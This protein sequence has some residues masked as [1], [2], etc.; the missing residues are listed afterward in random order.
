MVYSCLGG[1]RHC[2]RVHG[3]CRNAA[4]QSKSHPALVN[5][6]E[7][8]RGIKAT[9]SCVSFPSLV[10][11]T[12]SSILLSPPLRDLKNF[13][14]NTRLSSSLCTLKLLK[15]CTHKR[16]ANNN[17]YQ[18][19]LLG[20]TSQRLKN[21]KKPNSVSTGWARMPRVNT[22][23][24]RAD[25]LEDM[26]TTVSNFCAHNQSNL[27][28]KKKKKK[29]EKSLHE[30]FPDF[31]FILYIFKLNCLHSPESNAYAKCMTSKHISDLEA[32]RK[33]HS[34]L[35]L[36]L[37]FT[38]LFTAVFD[39]AVYSCVSLYCWQ[40]CFTALFTAV[41]HCAADSC[42]SLCCLQLCFTVLLTAV[43]LCCW[44]LF[45]CAVDS[46]FIVLFTAV[47]YCAVDSC[48]TVLLTAV[49]LCCL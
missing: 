18:W 1:G 5:L 45:H 2:Y 14:I 38:V 41:F 43:S 25:R 16:P 29:S 32:E 12:G 13:K 24:F 37:C 4:T 26:R 28:P 7:K 40:L 33:H 31:Y 19:M 36:Q 48:F 47:F 35:S 11:V 27:W 42:V 9:N 21:T 34:L 23:L 30:K 46:C 44:Q 15:V 10:S 3:E 22:V 20:K 49:S 17:E 8:G 6:W 39:S